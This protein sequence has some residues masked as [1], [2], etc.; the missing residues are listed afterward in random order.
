MDVQ[1]F[2]GKVPYP[3]LWAGSR[4]ARGKIA[5]SGIPNRLN[6]CVIFKVY[7]LLTNMA[8]GCIIQRGGSLET[9]GL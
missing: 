6:F 4:T 9:H 3:L 2:Y 5:I 1:T 8:G 7:T